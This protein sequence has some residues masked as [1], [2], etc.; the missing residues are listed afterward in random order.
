MSGI[1]THTG[2]RKGTKA[3]RGNDFYPTP[4]PLTR[5]LLNYEKLPQ[6]VWEPACGKGAMVE[7]LKAAGHL[8][9]ATDLID[10]KWGHDSRIDFLMEHK[11]P[12]VLLRNGQRHHV[13]SICTNPPFLL[14]NKFIRHAIHL[15]PHVCMLLRLQILASEGRMDLINDH[16]ARVYVFGPRVE[17]FQREDWEG[18]KL[19]KETG[20]FAWFVFERNHSKPATIQ[21][22][23]WRI[24][25]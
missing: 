19:E 6:H 10:Y 25:Q 16:L 9:V 1:A 2:N 4:A 11:A 22:I 15:C 3:E 5:A 13:Q 23:D 18:N 17:K 8:V 12:S 7:V 14:T 20:E 21:S 24:Y